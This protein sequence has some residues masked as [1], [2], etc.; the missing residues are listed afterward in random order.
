MPEISIV[1]KIYKWKPWISTPVRKPKI[2]MGWWCQEWLEKDETYKM[3]R[4]S[5]RSPQMES[6]CWEFQDS[7]QTWSAE[8]DGSVCTMKWHIGSPYLTYAFCLHLSKVTSEKLIKIQQHATVIA[9]TDHTTLLKVWQSVL[10]CWNLSL[11]PKTINTDTAMA[12]EVS[13]LNDRTCQYSQYSGQLMRMTFYLAAVSS[14]IQ[15]NVYDLQQLQG[16]AEIV[17]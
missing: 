8:E 12:R 11:V 16:A 9:K 4:T 10:T 14:G 15:T 17:N 7:Y 3:D 13:S 6:Y 5:P 2:A 1:K